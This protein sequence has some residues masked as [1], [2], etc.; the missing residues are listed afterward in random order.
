M[1]GM[2]TGI[3][4][5]MDAFNSD[6]FYE[7]LKRL[8]RQRLR[9]SAM[10]R[11]LR[12][13]EVL[14]DAYVL[15]APRLDPEEHSRRWIFF[16]VARA[17][18]DVVVEEARRRASLKRGGGNQR[19]DLEE[20][21]VDIDRM[22]PSLL[23]LSK[24]LASLAHVDMNA[25]D[26]VRLRYFAGLTYAQIAELRGCEPKDVRRDWMYAKAYLEPFLDGSVDERAA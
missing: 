15:I 10:A 21:E 7:E 24:G 17:V 18:H 2:A 22:G 11:Q 9:Q 19:V 25:A 14:H 8:A 13:T 23:G 16:L 20:P 4:R 6:H 26:T 12:T 1:N 3:G 5:H